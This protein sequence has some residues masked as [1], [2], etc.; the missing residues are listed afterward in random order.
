MNQYTPA[1][2]GLAGVIVGSALTVS[3]DYWFT[4]RSETKSRRYL[5]IRVVSSLERFAENCVSFADD[6]GERD[7]KGYLQPT[8]ES[9]SFN[10]QSLNVD[11]E[12]LPPLLLY[13]THDLPNKIQNANQV[14][15]AEWEYSASPPDYE[16]YFEARE[17]E[18]TELALEAYD[19]AAAMRL[20]AE[21]PARD[22]SKWDPVEYL[23][24]KQIAMREKLT[25]R[26]KK[27]SEL[28]GG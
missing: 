24:K 16:E 28:M 1:L 3:K 4:H 12:L 23:K 25:V 10:P 18:F 6:E 17:V 19:I 13:R 11:W 26:K 8:V 7:E 15:F 2:I 14:I 22:C 20:H 21:L 5:C 9:P 27:F